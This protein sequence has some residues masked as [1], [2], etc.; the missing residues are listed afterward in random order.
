MTAPVY[1]AGAVCWRLVEGRL[2]ILVIHRTQHKDVTLPKGKVEPG[3]SLPQT[4]VREVQ[5]ETGLGVALGV[6]LGST[7]YT[8]TGGRAKIVY[9][10]AA[11]VTEK[12]VLASTFV[13]NREVAALEWVS[14]KRA[15]EYL[16]FPHDVDIVEEFARLVDTG[17]LRT[18]ALIVL[19][20][21]KAV[22]PA[23]WDGRDS[24]RPLTG[25]GQTEATIAANALLAWRPKRL[26][27]S[28]AKRCRSTLMPLGALT[29][30]KISITEDLSQDC[31]DDGT[32][33]VRDAIGRRVRAKKTVVF[34]SHRPVIPEMLREIALATGT[35]T[36]HY[37]SEAA[38]LPTGGF[39][40][41]HLSS[42]HPASGIVS[43]ETH[44]PASA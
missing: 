6:P 32:A 39:S 22:P 44:A 11:E 43:I 19:R 9:Y 13:P 28:T 18:Y 20:H 25:R 33:R 40:V 34:S 31:F 35:P 2:R 4:A 16:T 24:T 7:E 42:A 17:V 37:L 23:S 5:E 36:G 12:A 26:V 3:E 8:I 27:S 41:L 29:K 38:E 14:I 10:W 15:R 30:R 1:A 21:G